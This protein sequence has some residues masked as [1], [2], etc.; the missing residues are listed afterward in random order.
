MGAVA[1]VTA[2]TKAVYSAAN[3]PRVFRVQVREALLPDR[4]AYEGPS[5]LEAEKAV[6][7]EVA[8]AL[9]F[10]KRACFTML[11]GFEGS[12][13]PMSELKRVVTGFPVEK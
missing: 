10:G 9:R 7:A 11:F 3:Y 1:E 13:S 6:L 4:C 2:E 5:E 12:T 8:Q